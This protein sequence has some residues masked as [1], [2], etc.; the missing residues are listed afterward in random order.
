MGKLR[1][2]RFTSGLGSEQIDQ[3][4]E[5]GR[6]GHLVGHKPTLVRMGSQE[7]AKLKPNI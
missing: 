3:S 7:T 6:P 2:K 5:R 4:G 1:C